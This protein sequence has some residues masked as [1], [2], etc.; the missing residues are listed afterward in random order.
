[1]VRVRLFEVFLTNQKV[2]DPH[3]GEVD[4][5]IDSYVYETILMGSHD[6]IAWGSLHYMFELGEAIARGAE[7]IRSFTPST[8]PLVRQAIQS[9][10]ESLGS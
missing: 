4:L 9:F 1:M 3:F 8:L 7:G 2:N 10:G 5:S 6:Q